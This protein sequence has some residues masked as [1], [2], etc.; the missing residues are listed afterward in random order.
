[1]PFTFVYRRV[2][3]ARVILLPTLTSARP[4]VFASQDA[5]PRWCAFSRNTAVSAS[6]FLPKPPGYS[7]VCRRVQ[8]CRCRS[9]SPLLHIPP[10]PSAFNL[11]KCPLFIRI[12][13]DFVCSQRIT[14]RGVPVAY[15][16]VACS[17]ISRAAAAY[18]PAVISGIC[19]TTVVDSAC[20]VDT[21]WP[22]GA[23]PLSIVTSSP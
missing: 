3:R 9:S 7:L 19:D 17:L 11:I 6:L 21:W 2:D 1:M 14:S 22:A 10:P 5:P 16:G 15:A 20:P 13:G 4:P 12:A 8:R 18:Y 23:P